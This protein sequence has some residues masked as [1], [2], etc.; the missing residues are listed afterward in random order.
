MRES[1]PTVGGAFF[2]NPSPPP[3]PDLQTTLESSILVL[4]GAMGTQLHERGIAFNSSF[5]TAN[6]DKPN[7]VQ[8]VH[9]SFLQAGADAIL[10]NTFGANRY[11]LGRHQLGDQ[12]QALL[13][14]GGSLARESA[15][16]QAYVIGSLGPLGVEL[17]PIGRLE[18]AEARLAFAESAKILAPFVDGFSLETFDNIAELEQAIRA[19]REVSDLPVM[20]FLTVG[21]DTR[22]QHG[23]TASSV[24]VRAANAGASMV[25]FNCSSGPRV[26]LEA[27]RQASQEIEL[28]LG[29][30]PNAG[31]PRQVDGRIFYENDPDYFARFARRFLQVGGQVIGGCC[32]TTPEHIRA[33]TRAARAGRQ[34]M[35]H[36]GAHP[37]QVSAKPK[38]A[39]PGVEPV[40]LKRR[41]A[42]GSAL[43][44]GRTV[45]SVE[46]V[47]PR[48]TDTS[49]LIHAARELHV[50]GVDAVN[51]PDGPRASAR[52]SNM[53]TATI[54]LRETRI[55]PLLHFCCRDRNLLGMQSDLLGAAALGLHNLLI[56]TGDPPYQGDYP[57]LTAVFDVD[58]IGLCNIVA[59]LNRGLDLGGNPLGSPTAF[60]FGGALNHTALDME[61]ELE[62][63]KWKVESGVNYLITQPVFDAAS[64]LEMEAHFPD[65]MPPVLAGIWP[66]RSLRNAEFLHSEVPGV[67]L[68]QVILERMRKAEDAGRAAEEGLLIATETIKDLQGK[69]AGFQV[70]APFNK[71]EP[72]LELTELIRAGD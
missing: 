19:V 39:S 27:V 41:S 46:L 40:P 45:I 64:L 10:T 43:A 50:A 34:H 6:V 11:R 33:I 25:G 35:H 9:Q 51:L 3:R 58:A 37:H 20:A 44:S 13:E 55:E 49:K 1:S 67:R 14:A 72:A 70:A 42:F 22:T 63:L 69:V 62:R 15:G 7:W 30:K 26:V 52:L 32:G 48:T 61:R 54:L 57:D 60:C 28:P 4:D 5:E 21:D 23:A 8:E 68:P 59:N 47:P 18:E 38:K 29:A 17:E 2:M 65:D 56:V 71:V 12:L 31:M 66:L 53:A 16:D 24:A 36:V